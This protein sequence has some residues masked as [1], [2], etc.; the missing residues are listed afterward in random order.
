MF[1]LIGNNWSPSPF[2]A[3]IFITCFFLTLFCTVCIFKFVFSSA[4]HNEAIFVAIS[5]GTSL[6]YGKVFILTSVVGCSVCSFHA[7]YQKLFYSLSKFLSSAIGSNFLY[8][9]LRFVLTS[10]KS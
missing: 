7:C 9:F 5:G 1:A 2:W 6:I 3:L 4:D 10:L 8:W